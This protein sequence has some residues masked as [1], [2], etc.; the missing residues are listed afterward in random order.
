MTQLVMA[1][2]LCT[3]IHTADNIEKIY[4]LN[5]ILYCLVYTILWDI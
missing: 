2:L 1:T 4:I 5:L 3:L